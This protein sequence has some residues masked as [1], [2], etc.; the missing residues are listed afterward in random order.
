M[1]LWLAILFYLKQG[2]EYLSMYYGDI[3]VDE[4]EG[5]PEATEGQEGEILRRYIEGYRREDSQ[6]EWFEKIKE[7]SRELGYAERV[8]EY[9]KEPEKYRGTITDVCTVIR[10]AVTGRAETPDLYTICKLMGEKASVRLN[11]AL[12]KLK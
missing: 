5:Y 2:K 10:V 4:R 9:K 8:K 1:M 6:E 3:G 12:F 7:I 11:M